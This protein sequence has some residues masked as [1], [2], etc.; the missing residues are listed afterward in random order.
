MVVANSN[1]SETNTSMDINRLL[2]D[3][4]IRHACKNDNV[5]KYIAELEQSLDIKLKLGCQKYVYYYAAQFVYHLDA[6]DKRSFI[7]EKVR[8]QKMFSVEDV[9]VHS[10]MLTVKFKFHPE[11]AL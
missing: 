4:S 6:L 5:N 10:R 11:N 2:E 3:I 1:I 8:H 9:D 7:L